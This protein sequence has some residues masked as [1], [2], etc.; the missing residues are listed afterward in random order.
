M[1]N[2]IDWNIEMDYFLPKIYG[3]SSG[4]RGS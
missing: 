4:N 1:K 3:F 2:G